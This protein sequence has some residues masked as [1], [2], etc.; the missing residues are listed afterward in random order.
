[1]II[2]IKN[3][4]AIC[5]IEAQKIL[6]IFWRCFLGFCAPYILWNLLGFIVGDPGDGGIAVFAKIILFIMIGPIIFALLL[7]FIF[8]LASYFEKRVKN[9]WFIFWFA[10]FCF[11]FWFLNL[12][13]NI[14]FIV[15]IEIA[16]LIIILFVMNIMQ[17][18]ISKF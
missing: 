11:V 8:Y 10:F 2:N 5:W 15:S 6:K 9:H 16:T 1:M 18:I 12:D 14:W 17:K 3:I 13:K 4:L 7:S